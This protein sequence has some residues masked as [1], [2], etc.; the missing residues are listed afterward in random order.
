MERPEEPVSD[1]GRAA[2]NT[3]IPAITSSTPAPTIRFRRAR[4]SRC[5]RARAAPVPPEP[6]FFFA[7]AL[8][9]AAVFFAGGTPQSAGQQLRDA[10]DTLDEVV[11]AQR[12]REPGEARG[13]ERLAGDDGDLGLL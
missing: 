7:A 3:P 6:V 10:V 2:K 13:A 12:V 11:V 1:L 9:A 4:D 8:R 5:W